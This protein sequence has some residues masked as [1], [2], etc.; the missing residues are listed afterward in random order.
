[1]VRSA[2]AFGGGGTRPLEVVDEKKFWR[3]SSL[4]VD[5]GGWDAGGESQSKNVVAEGP[6]ESVVDVDC[7][8]RLVSLGSSVEAGC[9]LAIGARPPTTSLAHPKLIPFPSV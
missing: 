8:K 2:V 6:E 7:E 3:A 1:M 5:E 9:F 4:E